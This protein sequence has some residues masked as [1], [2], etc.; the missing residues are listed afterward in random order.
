MNCSTCAGTG[1]PCWI[2]G[3]SVALTLDF[4]GAEIDA[5]DV[6]L[7]TVKRAL[8]A[9]PADARAV[10]RAEGELQSDGSVL[11]TLASSD[12]VSVPPGDY[13]WDIRIV[14]AD[15]ESIHTRPSSLCVHQPVTNRSA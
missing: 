2:R 12:T 11:I 8:D 13:L 5:S 15:G 4:M 3:D 9:D 6:I 1:S 7:F 14:R 10:I